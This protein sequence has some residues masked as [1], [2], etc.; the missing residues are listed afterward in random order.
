MLQEN[1]RLSEEKRELERQTSVK[2]DELLT[3][4]T[5]LQ[6]QL[7][8]QQVAHERAIE[9]LQQ[10]NSDLQKQ[11]ESMEKQLKSN[12]HFLEVCSLTKFYSA[13]HICVY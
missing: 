1:S 3:E 2:R 5:E 10:E 11:I 13:S 4:I 6:E 12:R 9:A 7:E 8:D